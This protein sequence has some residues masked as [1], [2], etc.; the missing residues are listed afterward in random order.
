[1]NNGPA[2]LIEELE[3][4]SKLHIKQSTQEFDSTLQ[5]HTAQ[6]WLAA[7]L[8]PNIEN[9]LNREFLN[10]LFEYANLHILTTK[11]RVEMQDWQIVMVAVAKI[12]SFCRTQSYGFFIA[13]CARNPL[14]VDEICRENFI[15]KLN[16]VH[17]NKLIPYLTT[18][19]IATLLEILVQN[20][21]YAP[22][23]ECLV[24]FCIT[25]FREDVDFALDVLKEPRLA[26]IY[27]ENG[28]QRAFRHPKLSGEHYKTLGAFFA[29]INADIS[30][31]Y[32]SFST[33]KEL[34]RLAEMLAEQTFGD[35]QLEP[36]PQRPQTRHPVLLTRSKSSINNLSALMVGE[37]EEVEEGE[38]EEV[39]FRLRLGS[40][41][42]GDN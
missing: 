19:H 10:K 5:R 13:Y 12:D 23:H 15:T 38:E 29:T 3:L 16:P 11:R 22:L 27:S 26:C 14:L 25:K 40:S 30:R 39:T 36:I 6:E 32:I 17:L 34:E 1:M 9:L 21:R 2:T 41:S 33:E 24:A 4:L 37:V 8:D 28:A 18:G 7:L 20:K 42:E 35:E 31:A